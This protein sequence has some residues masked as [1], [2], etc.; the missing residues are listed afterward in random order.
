MRTGR[1]SARPRRRDP[2][3]ARRGAGAGAVRRS[4][5]RAPPAGPRPRR[6]SS[7]GRRGG[8]RVRAGR[9][10]RSPRASRLPPA[11]A[12]AR[13]GNATFASTLRWGKRAPP[14]NATPSGRRSGGRSSI[15]TSS[16]SIEHRVRRSARPW[17]ARR[18][19]CRR[20]SGRGGRGSRPPRPRS[21][22]APRTPRAATRSPRRG[23]R[24]T[25]DEPCREGRSETASDSDDE[26]QRQD[27]RGSGIGSGAPR[28]R[29]A[30]SSGS[31]PRK[32]PANVIVAP[33]SPSARAH[34][35]TAPAASCGARSRKRDPPEDV[36]LRCPE[37]GGRILAAACR[38]T[39]APPRP[40]GRRTGTTRR[41]PRRRARGRERELE[42]DG[43]RRPP[44]KPR[45]PNAVRS[46][47]PR[48]PAGGRAGRTSART[49]EIPPGTRSGRA[50]GRGARRR[51][52]RWRRRR[53]TRSRDTRSP[54]D[55]RRP[56]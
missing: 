10:W 48:R 25:P 47:I 34:A 46:P 8:R 22:R 23:S 41:R 33:N 28:T 1:S 18:S 3:A 50:A 20:R 54:F 11:D 12:R 43:S 24:P 13:S 51:A 32:L 31:R 53:A 39:G 19:S 42:P 38:A 4:P 6:A 15:R 56:K 40:R 29:R 30:A 55:A 44:E 35:S 26:H 27:R 17:R 45:R 36:P 37:R 49:T 9:G 52:A 21:S 14:W 5:G 2:R 7:A 16:S